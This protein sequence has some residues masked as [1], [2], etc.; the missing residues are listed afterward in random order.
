MDEPPSTG[1][2]MAPDT[3]SGPLDTE[4][5]ITGANLNGD[6]TDSSQSLDSDQDE[7][8]KVGLFF[9]RFFLFLPLMVHSPLPFLSVVSN[10]ILAC[11]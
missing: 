6:E 4:I 1:P 3:D 9:P 5:A 7:E 11:F 10:Y 2:S 8:Q